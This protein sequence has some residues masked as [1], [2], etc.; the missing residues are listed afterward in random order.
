MP[1]LLL[2]D[3]G[4]TR[5]KFAHCQVTTSGQL[6]DVLHSLAVLNSEPVPWA[7]V[8]DWYGVAGPQL[9]VVTGTNVANARQLVGNWPHGFAR[10]RLIEDKLSLP[11]QMDVDVPARVGMDRLLNS[12]AA[13]V[14]RSPGQ[15]AICIDSGTAITV[16]VVSA[17]GVFLGGAILPGILLGAKSLHEETTTLPHVNV[18]ELLKHEPPVLGKNTEAAIASGLYWG[19]LGAVREL[20]DRYSALLQNSSPPL[21]LLTGGAA[22]I[23]SPY[24]PELQLLPDLSLQGLAVAA[25]KLHENH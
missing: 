6:P 15:P 16:D 8:R 25:A 9:A 2:C 19:H 21:K 18:W 23:L 5:V 10:P 13:N 1:E 24:L 17:D 3:A 22:V 12:V 11:L 7:D 20:V 4:H 14:L